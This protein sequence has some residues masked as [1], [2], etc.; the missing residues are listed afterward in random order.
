MSINIF[1]NFFVIFVTTWNMTSFWIRQ[2]Q[3][4]ASMVILILTQI[5]DSIR[6]FKK[7]NPKEKAQGGQDKEY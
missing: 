5:F 1:L 2:G 4:I 3:L 6:H 7:M